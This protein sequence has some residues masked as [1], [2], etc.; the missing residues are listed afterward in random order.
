MIVTTLLYP[1]LKNNDS[2][3]LKTNWKYSMQN[4]K[5]RNLSKYGIA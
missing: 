4:K 2:E 3:K 5:L 1:T